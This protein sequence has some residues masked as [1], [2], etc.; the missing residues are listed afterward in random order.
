[1]S[2]YGS[3]VFSLWSLVHFMSSPLLT[4]TAVLPYSRFLPFSSVASRY[5]SLLTLAS[6]SLSVTRGVLGFCPHPVTF[7]D[8]S[9]NL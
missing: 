9:G 8:T 2:L 7:L 5:V 1:M 4:V 3:V 6:G